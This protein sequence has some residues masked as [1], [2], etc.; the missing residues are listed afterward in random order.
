L[1]APRHVHHLALR[2]TRPAELAAWYTRVLGLVEK[3]R[4]D[5]ALGL[6]SVWLDLGDTILMVERAV[7]V[8]TA[9]PSRLGWEGVYLTIPASGGEEW[10]RRLVAYGVEIEEKTSYTLYFR[11]PDGN[12]LGLS[13]FPHPLSAEN[14]PKG[15]EPESD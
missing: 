6:R 10:A 5:D 1:N 11:D 3:A 9:G 8:A 15:P 2:T 13:S 12:R 14:S 4:Q 7:A